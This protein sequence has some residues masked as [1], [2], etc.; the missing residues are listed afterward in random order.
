M[1]LGSRR[2]WEEYTKAKEAV[3]E[4]SHFPRRVVDRGGATKRRRDSIASITCSP[5]FPTARSSHAPIA[6]P[7]RIRHADYIR[8]PVPAE[9]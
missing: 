6:L 3:L 9:M 2:R 5:R 1:D 4:R 8:G 7:R